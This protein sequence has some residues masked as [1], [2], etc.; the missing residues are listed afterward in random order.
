LGIIARSLTIVSKNKRLDLRKAEKI[1]LGMYRIR[2]VIY[3]TPI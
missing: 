3:G 2:T 1:G